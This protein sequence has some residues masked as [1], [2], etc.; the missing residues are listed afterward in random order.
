MLETWIFIPSHQGGYAFL[1]RCEWRAL[2]RDTSG[3]LSA[4][5]LPAHVLE[6]H[7]FDGF[8]DFSIW[9]QAGAGRPY[10]RAQRRRVAVRSDTVL[11]GLLEQ[12]F[13]R[14]ALPQAQ[15]A[16][17]ADYFQALLVERKHNDGHVRRVA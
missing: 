13:N 6:I 16:E 12:E 7:R 2:Q 11:H 8:L 4:R 15:Q 10:T 3:W 1:P 14:H 17:L 9:T 5:C